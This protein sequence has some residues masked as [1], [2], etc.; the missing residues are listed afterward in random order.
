MRH[1]NIATLLMAGLT[2][3]AVNTT[4]AAALTDYVGTYDLYYTSATTDLSIA[5]TMPDGQIYSFEL[6]E[7]VELVNEKVP[8]TGADQYVAEAIAAVKSYVPNLPVK[9]EQKLVSG[10]TRALYAVIDEVN[11]QTAAFPDSTALSV[12]SSRT[13]S[14]QAICADSDGGSEQLV[15]VG[16]MKPDT[17]AFDFMSIYV[18][19]I[20]STG[21]YTGYGTWGIPDIDITQPVQGAS[22]HVTGSIMVEADM[23]KL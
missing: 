18:G 22:V 6:D 9:L 20:S 12:L 15:L 10:M 3:G 1:F 13:N 16:T 21:N 2:L 8:Y 23:V 14:V 7:V 4:S 5:V 17:G 11:V 19:S